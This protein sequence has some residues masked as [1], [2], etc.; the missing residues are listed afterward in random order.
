M[1]RYRWYLAGGVLLVATNWLSTI[2]LY[3]AQARRL[4][5]GAG[6]PIVFRSASPSRPWEPV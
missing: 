6:R 5:L 1:R 4:A 3:L 2:P